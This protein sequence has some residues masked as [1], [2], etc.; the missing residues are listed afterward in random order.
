MAWWQREKRTGGDS[1]STHG[2]AVPSSDV[3]P[4]RYK[5][6]PLLIILEN[7][8][9]DSIGALTIDRQD[10]LRLIVEKVFGGGQDWKKTVRDRLDLPDSIDATFLQIWARNQEIAKKAGEEL[11]PVKFAKMI[12]DSNF[13]SLIGPPLG[14]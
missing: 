11:H 9:L 7:Y 13:A 10:G 12:V 6:R 4:E 8:V 14:D 5:G 1:S 2:F 3:G